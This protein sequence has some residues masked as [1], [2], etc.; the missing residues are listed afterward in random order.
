M[1]DHLGYLLASY[2]LA[3]LVFAV[4]PALAALRLR[5]ARRALTTLG[6]DA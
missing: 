3:A 6:D 1:N 4:E 5:R 2:G